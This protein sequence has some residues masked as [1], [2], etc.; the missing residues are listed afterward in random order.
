M[1]RALRG[2]AALTLTAGAVA[3]GAPATPSAT[4]AWIALAEVGP[5]PSRAHMDARPGTDEGAGNGAD[6]GADDGGA[7]PQD[8]A[9]AAVDALADSRLRRNVEE[10]LERGLDWLAIEQAQTADGS[11]PK[12]SAEKHAPVGVTALA[13]LAYKAAG[14][15]PDRGPHAMAL[16]RAIDYLLSR[17]DLTPG[18][19]PIGYIGTDGDQHSRMHG[20][21]FAAHH[22]GAAINLG[23]FALDSAG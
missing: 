3:A 10:A 15:T 6:D 8:E 4:H 18:S 5:S 23:F 9:R 14:T 21:G 19:K 22:A 1:R 12:G 17:A 7:S 2:A 13:A 16:S 20:H 11:F